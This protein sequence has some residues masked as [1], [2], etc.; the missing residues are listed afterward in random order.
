MRQG[1]ARAEFAR[2]RPA[3]PFRFRYWL[4]NILVLATMRRAM[5]MDRVKRANSGAAPVS[6]DLPKWFWAMG[7]PIFEGWKPNRNHGHWHC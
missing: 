3:C 2:D 4:A 5:G 6:P 1:Q 7:V